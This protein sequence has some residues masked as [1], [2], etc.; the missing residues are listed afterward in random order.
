[1]LDLNLFYQ[2]FLSVL[3]TRKVEIYFDIC[4]IW[5][6]KNKKQNKTK[7][8]KKI[9][10]PS[11]EHTRRNSTFLPTTSSRKVTFAILARAWIGPAVKSKWPGLHLSLS[12]PSPSLFLTLARSPFWGICSHLT[13]AGN[14][15]RMRA[16]FLFQ[17]Y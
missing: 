15:S 14:S 7:Q 17:F 12:L 6:N 8:K 11:K 9:R 16:L 4:H 3:C 2:L 10:I 1:M 13:L 5:Y